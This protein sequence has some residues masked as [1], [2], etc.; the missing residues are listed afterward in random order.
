MDYAPFS[1]DD[2]GSRDITDY[3]TG[4]PHLHPF[5]GLHGTPHLAED[6]DLLPDDGNLQARGRFDV[7]V[8]AGGQSLAGMGSDDPQIRQGNHSPAVWTTDRQGSSRDAHRSLAEAAPGYL[9]A[10]TL[11][12]NG[13]YNVAHESDQLPP[14]RTREQ[15][16]RVLPE[17]GGEP[18][19]HASDAVIVF[20]Q[21]GLSEWVSTAGR[22]NANQRA[23]RGVY[24]SMGRA[25]ARFTRRNAAPIE[26]D[27]QVLGPLDA[28]CRPSLVCR[29][30][31]AEIAIPEMGF[32]RTR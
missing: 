31:G 23:A 24:W 16:P 19:M 25:S 3:V 14:D 7:N 26:L 2:L 6:S 9:C 27:A 4:R 8:A 1:H 30:V 28:R 13:K 29:E 20:P 22:L 32:S 10:C 17:R 12:H 18:I 21:A 11:E 5:A 15:E